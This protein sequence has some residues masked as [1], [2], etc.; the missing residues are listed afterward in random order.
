VGREEWVVVYGVPTKMP[1]RTLGSILT[2]VL[3]VTRT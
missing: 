3:C 1:E 2:S